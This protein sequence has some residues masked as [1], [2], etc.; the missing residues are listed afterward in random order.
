MAAYGTLKIEDGDLSHI[1]LN[2]PWI[3]PNIFRKNE[4][5]KNFGYHDYFKRKGL[6]HM[7]KVFM[8]KKIKSLKSFI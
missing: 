6:K 3:L 2:H 1:T 4:N 5:E 7:T 8:Q